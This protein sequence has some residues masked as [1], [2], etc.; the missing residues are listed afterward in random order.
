MMRKWV[1]EQGAVGL[2][3]QLS[4]VRS[5]HANYVLPTLCSL[6]CAISC[7]PEWVPL[8]VTP[9]S[10]IPGIILL[11]PAFLTFWLVKEASNGFFFYLREW[12][13]R[14]ATPWFICALYH[15]LCFNIFISPSVLY[16]LQRIRIA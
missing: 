2:H 3:E 13:K 9:C 10:S 14:S 15:F 7:S 6:L 11:F 8:V 5:I 1:E 12:R 16:A 4:R